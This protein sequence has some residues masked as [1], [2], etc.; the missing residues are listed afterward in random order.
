MFVYR[1]WLYSPRFA[2][3]KE[4]IVSRAMTK[5]YYEDMM[6]TAVSDVIISAC[7]FLRRSVHRLL[8]TLLG[9]L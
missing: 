6:K 5:R 7:S 2:P 4:H 3:I 8:L 1:R 9:F